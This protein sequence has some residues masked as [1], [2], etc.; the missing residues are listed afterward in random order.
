[1]NSTHKPVCILENLKHPLLIKS[2]TN[3]S[4]IISNHFTGHSL[5]GS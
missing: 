4:F 2:V 1:M 5:D 3:H